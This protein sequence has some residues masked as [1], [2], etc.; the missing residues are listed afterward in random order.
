MVN[1]VLKCVGAEGTFATPPDVTSEARDLLQL[2]LSSFVPQPAASWTSPATP[3]HI[4]ILEW[5]RLAAKDPDDQPTIWLRD[6]APAGLNMPIIDRGVFPLYSWE[7]DQP[8]LHADELQTEEHFHN[9]SD[10]EESA[11]VQGEF[12]RLLAA[13]HLLPFDSLEEVEGY[14][15]AQAVLS[16][17]GH[18]QKIRN[19][20]LKSRIVIDSKR[21]RVSRAA[22]RFDRCQLP[23]LTDVVWDALALMATILLS[24]I[25]I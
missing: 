4:R 23:R 3:I 6:G 9:Y 10:V 1:E 12:A 21:S 7:D 17:I 16:R 8:E 2:V 25:H 22:R 13:G 11:A 20:K 19:G 15:E 14:L 18:I 24:L 5:W